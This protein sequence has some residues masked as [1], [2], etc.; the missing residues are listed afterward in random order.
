VSK[1]ELLWLITA[2]TPITTSSD[3]QKNTCPSKT[4]TH[5]P[6]IDLYAW[7][8]AHKERFEKRLENKIL[9]AKRTFDLEN[10]AQVTKVVTDA[11]GHHAAEKAK[12]HQYFNTHI[13]KI[14]GALELTPVTEASD[15][16]LFIATKA[17]DHFFVYFGAMTAAMVH[18]A[19]WMV[20]PAAALVSGADAAIHKPRICFWMLNTFYA[21][22]MAALENNGDQKDIDKLETVLDLS[23]GLEYPE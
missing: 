22:Q 10:S 5:T 12:L 11:K 18:I 8:E 2:N 21:Q 13:D 23:E 6:F 16:I 14:A 4:C 17:R 1:L 7:D 20:V 15:K 9:R 19:C 3:R